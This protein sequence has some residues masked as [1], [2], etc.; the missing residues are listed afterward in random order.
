MISR[1]SPGSDVEE[2]Q[3]FFFFLVP[4]LSVYML[5]VQQQLLCN[6]VKEGTQRQHLVVFT[7]NLIP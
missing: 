4:Q 3:A 7:S 1:N 2:K 6:A 5:L